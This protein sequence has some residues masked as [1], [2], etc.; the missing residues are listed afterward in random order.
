MIDILQKIAQYKIEEVRKS[1]EIRPLEKLKEK[2]FYTRDCYSAKAAILK[3]ETGII[4]EFKR[5]SP[6]KPSINLEAV[7]TQIIPSYA[8]HGASAIS[9]LT[10]NHFF[11]GDIAF[12][13]ENREV[14]VPFLR[15]EFIIDAYQV[16]EA[17]AYGADFILLIAAILTKEQI[18]T[19]TDLTHELGMEVLLE[20]HAGEELDKMYKAVDLVGI[21]NRNLKT[22]EVNLNH[23]IQMRA[24]LSN[25]HICVAE[26]GIQSVEDYIQLKHNGF[27][28]F[29]M[30]EYFMKHSNPGLAL[31]TF[32]QNVK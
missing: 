18:I 30:G 7:S 31:E 6:S 21:N 15:K 3:S 9:I 5:K 14:E 11:G 22:F 12:M 23:A 1:K 28:A 24:S 16:Y 19:F 29:L 20:F 10:D 17:K 4:A 32:I 8:D 25:N 2:P 13:S 27:D 26:S